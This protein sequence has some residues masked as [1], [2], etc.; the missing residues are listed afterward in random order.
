MTI[1]N[2]RLIPLPG[3]VVT[4]L[5]SDLVTYWNAV[6]FCD[7]LGGILGSLVRETE[8]EVTELL[9]SGD[10]CDVYEACRLTAEFEFTRRLH[11]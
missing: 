3:S 5:R 9:E 4:E 10:P 1:V 2:R 8:V 6:A 7:D 11:T